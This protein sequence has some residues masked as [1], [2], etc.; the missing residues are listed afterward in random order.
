MALIFFSQS[1][2]NTCILPVDV[3]V[4]RHIFEQCICGILKEKTRILVTH[5]LQLLTSVKQIILLEDGC[6]KGKGNF[7]TISSLEASQAVVKSPSRMVPVR[8]R[9]GS[10][11]STSSMP[12]V[13][14]LSGS[15][16]LGNEPGVGSTYSINVDDYA[17]DYDESEDFSGDD[18]ETGGGEED[19]LSK[20]ASDGNSD[21]LLFKAKSVPK[22]NEEL[23]ATGR[24][25]LGLYIQYFKAG[26]NP[27]TAMVLILS[28]IVT[29]VLY[30]GSDW[31]LSLW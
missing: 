13:G 10:E 17:E 27:F 19:K 21:L 26:S 3:E 6:I 28:N 16:G 25:G 5:Q 22:E 12:F 7:E 18:G 8:N 15:F 30:A 23:A 1:K 9:A 31:W 29:Q 2:T 11:H 24:V 4:A 20:K 14:M